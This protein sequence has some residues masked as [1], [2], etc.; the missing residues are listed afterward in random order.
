MGETFCIDVIIYIICAI[1]WTVAEFINQIK[2]YH[3]FMAKS[4]C[5]RLT[6]EILEIGMK[7]VQ[8]QQ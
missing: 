3:I 7:C 5:S 8:S 2:M 6:I 1:G 4:T